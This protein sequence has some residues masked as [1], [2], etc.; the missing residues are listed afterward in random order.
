VVDLG[1]REACALLESKGQALAP[2]AWDDLHSEK[3]ALA[4]FRRHL[5]M[6]STCRDFRCG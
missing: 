1:S 2:P 3:P 5:S 4:S 6:S